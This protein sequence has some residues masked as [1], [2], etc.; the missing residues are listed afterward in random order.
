MGKIKEKMTVYCSK[1][2]KQYL[3]FKFYLA[4]F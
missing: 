3:N 1:D 4:Y 2:M